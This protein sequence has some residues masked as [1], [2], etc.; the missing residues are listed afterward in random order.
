LEDFFHDGTKKG[1][2]PKHAD[3]LELILDR[4]NASSVIKDMNYP[5][6]GRT[7]S[8][9]ELTWGNRFGV[10]VSGNWRVTFKFFGG[11]AYIMSYKDYH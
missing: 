6:S 2:Q 1:I 8:N 9:Q 10:N 7:S 3:K 5:G 11:D 4:L